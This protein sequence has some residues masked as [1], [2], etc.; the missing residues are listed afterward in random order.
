MRCHAC[1]LNGSCRVLTMRHRFRLW[2]CRHR[3]RNFTW[4]T[5][6]ATSPESGLALVRAIGL[7]GLTAAIHVYPRQSGSPWV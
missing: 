6:P 7:R 3:Q 1:F 2:R 5:T 4:M